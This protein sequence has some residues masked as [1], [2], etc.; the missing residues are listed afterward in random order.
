MSPTWDPKFK[1][2]MDQ[3][4]ASPSMPSPPA[5]NTEFWEPGQ[6]LKPA[7]SNV[8]HTRI[9]RWV[10]HAMQDTK[11]T[12]GLKTL[13]MKWKDQSLE[14]N[15]QNAELLHIP[16]FKDLIFAQTHIHI[17]FMIRRISRNRIYVQFKKYLQL[18][19]KTL[20]E[21]KGN[22]LKTWWEWYSRWKFQYRKEKY[23]NTKSRGLINKYKNLNSQ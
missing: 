6:K 7:V 10:A 13:R 1:A 20:D 21:I 5:Y 2:A 17:S 16:Y 9:K 22:C 11:S 23:E 3:T 18:A 15:K 4:C 19:H 8:C 14:E 12:T